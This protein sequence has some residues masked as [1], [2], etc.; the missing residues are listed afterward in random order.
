[1]EFL[2]YNTKDKTIS[3]VKFDKNVVAKT[4]SIFSLG[5]G[6]L[7]IRSAD[8]EV[9]SYNKEDFFVNGIFNKDNKNEVSELA[10]LADLLSTPIY[11]NKKAF[12][13]SEQDEYN[14]TLHIKTGI[15]T[16]EV[17]AKRGEYK[18]ALNFERFVS[19]A[20]KNVYAQ[21]ITIKVLKAPEK[22]NVLFKAGINGQVTNNGTQHFMEGLK[23][24]PTNES[25]QMQQK[26]TLSNRFVVHNMV[27]RL[28]VNG[29]RIYGGNDDYVIDI[30]RRQ[31]FFKINL[32]LK[33]GD[34]VILEKLMS[35]HTSVDS[36]NY[37]LNDEV[38]L[39][40][41]KDELSK[42]LDATYDELKEASIAA[43]DS[44]VWER[45]FVEIKG[46]KEAEY[47]SLALDF[48]IFHLN[49]FVPTTSTNM[50]VG[51]KG[52][53]GEGYQGHTYWDTEFFINPIYL[54]N[55][56]QVVRNLLTYRFKGL[57]GARK[58]ALETKERPEESKLIGAQYP[59][60]MAWPTEGEVCPYWGQ[61]DVVSGQQVPIAS[62]RQEIHVSADVAYA[63]NQYYQITKDNKF[64]NK[65]G[66]QMVFETA[67]F[68]TNRA[69]LQPDGSYEIK[70]VMGPNE[71]KGN[72]DNNAYINMMAKYN[73]DL[74]L[75]Y[76]YKLSQDE[77]SKEILD[78][79][80][81]KIPYKLNIS[82]MKKVSKH[83]K[84]QVPNKD[85][86]IAEN[87][88][89]L[90]LPKIDVKP[91]QM[92][93][94]AGKKLFSTAE[95]HKRL[96]SQL[97]KQA[98]VVLLLNLLP[99]LFDKEIRKANFDY[100]EDITTHDSSLS[101]ATYSIE[102]ARLG[103]LEK[104]YHLFKYGI[105]IDLGLNMSSSNAGIHAGSLAA[106]YQMIVFGF[107]GLDWHN[108][109]LHLNPILPK[110]WDSLKYRFQ[111]QGSTFEVFVQQDK[112]SIQAINNS[113]PRTISIHGKDILVGAMQKTY[114][115][116]NA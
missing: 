14:K 75:K 29:Q 20:N 71:Y 62:R 24:R 77:K 55:D 33:E 112:F 13:V 68:Y 7:G 6:Y 70:D 44:K 87:D 27:T 105:N 73:I 28:F 92:L 76:I 97:V 23:S 50:N 45:F 5:N 60:E 72:I 79:I 3:Q 89:F 88:Q 15:L 42:L 37:V 99:H 65:M 26:T 94:D 49:N 96:C 57:A 51:A 25:L 34:E 113:K 66:Y 109:K 91:F 38:V 22:A 54:F 18:Y 95:G 115:V 2:K 101:P 40:A 39:N 1:M 31:I 103:M 17:I 4:E 47:D 58:K 8:E 82:K 64:M 104:A 46:G 90:G 74:A 16:R 9:T 19:Q 10:N 107:G 83:L 35:V 36:K 21:K 106:I 67:Y 98:D 43:M 41:A 61:A 69:E 11:L 114:E 110:E 111:Y 93:G 86:I 84:Q 81:R 80:L 32:N 52:L 102:A 56:P 78:F 12:E 100:Y 108:D 116:K 30:Q 63:I 59:W 53:S 85:L 48:G